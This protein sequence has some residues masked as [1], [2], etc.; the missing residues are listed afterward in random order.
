MKIKAVRQEKRMPLSTWRTFNEKK[1]KLIQ[2]L[3][4]ARRE[5][6]KIIYLDEICFTKRSFMG[7]TWSKRHEN[8][9]VDQA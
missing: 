2:E 3:K 8:I 4:D 1:A 6:R 9:R 7:T 5:G